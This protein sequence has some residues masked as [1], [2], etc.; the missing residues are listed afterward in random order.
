ME[1]QS[2]TVTVEIAKLQDRIQLMFNEIGE[3]NDGLIKSGISGLS[4]LVE[5]YESVV[6]IIGTL[7]LTYGSY[8]AALI[9]TTATQAAAGGSAYALA[10]AWVS[11]TA[12]LKVFRT[13]LKTSPVG[14]YTAVTTALGLAF[15]SLSKT[16][17]T[18]NSVQP[19]FYSLD[20]TPANLYCQQR[21]NE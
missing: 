17:N 6:G 5:N 12:S 9:L 14:A 13:T 11:F 10:K 16:I 4:F 21:E 20:R 8:R 7:I 18:A 19:L 2:K 1:K 3:G 15:Y